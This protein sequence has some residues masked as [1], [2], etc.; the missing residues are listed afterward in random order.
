MHNAPPR[1]VVITGAA[2]ALGQAVAA[3][4][5]PGNN[6]VLINRHLAEA[7]HGVLS[8][9]ADVTSDTAMAH[10]ASLIARRFGSVE[11]VVHTAGGFEM[12]EPVNELSRA[13]WDRLMDL[14]AWSFVTVT[15]H[16]VPLIRG[17]S[18][19]SI[20]A[21]SAASAASGDAYKGAYAASKA[22]LQRLVESQAAE[23]RGEGIRVNSVAPTVLDTPANRAAMPDADP[24]AWTPLPDAARAIAFLLSD[25]ARAVTGRHVVLG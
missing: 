24:S 19:G 23:L 2:G 21:V 12:G 7:P 8:L 14:N 4:L 9:A 25:A 13:T 22:A 17:G 6:L 20:V 15:K 16:L 10:A 1:T 5:G 3:E 18:G 11:M